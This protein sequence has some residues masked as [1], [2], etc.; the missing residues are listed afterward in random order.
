MYHS[1]I[2]SGT[3]NDYCIGR[4]VLTDWFLFSAESL[5]APPLIITEEEIK[6]ACGVIIEAL[7]NAKK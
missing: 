7:G 2:G 4:G 1:P 3:P 6:E 5:L